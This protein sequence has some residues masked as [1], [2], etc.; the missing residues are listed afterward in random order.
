MFF[1]LTDKS[2][3]VVDYFQML[4]AI[5][6]LAAA[7]FA[8]ITTIQNRKANKQIE[9][10]RHMMVKP[11]YRIQST[12]EQRTEKIIKINAINIGYHRTMNQIAG[13][14][15]GTPG[16]NVS[17]KEVIRKGNN[18]QNNI[19]IEIIMNCSDCTEKKIEG[20]LS[21]IYTNILGKQYTES[22]PIEAENIFNEYAEEEFLIL[23]EGLTKQYF[24]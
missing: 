17:V 24:L 12:S 14:W 8:M 6:T 18:E 20:T 11:S 1:L 21:I 10:E 19:D 16:V 23:K 5:G 3:S 13:E 4:G 2:L 15:N 7:L 22:V 9:F